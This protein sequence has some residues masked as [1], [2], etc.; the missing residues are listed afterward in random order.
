M[1]ELIQVGRRT[2]YINCPSKIGVY[3]ATDSGAYIIDSGNDK[4]AGKKIKKILD[5]NS[6]ELKG[7]IN[8]HSHADHIGG[9]RYLQQQTGCR[10]F[11]K[12]IEGSFTKATL[13]EPAL[14]YGG[15]P[16]KDLRHKFLMA[17]ESRCEDINS[18]DFPKELEVVD[19]PGHYFEMIGIKT[20]DSVFFLADSVS[21]GE[22]LQKYGIPFI[23]DIGGYLE[24]LDKIEKIPAQLYVPSHAGAVSDI[25]GLAEINRRSVL[26]TAD[27]IKE[28]ISAPLNFEEILKRLF[29][30]YGLKMSFMQYAL[31]GST[32]KSY[33]AWLKDNNQADVE[34]RDNLLLWHR[35]Q[36][37][38]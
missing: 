8:T 1:Y 13:L 29:D 30:F 31:V 25:S 35:V 24:T 5:T 38:V 19:L 33:L 2:Y 16:P 9:N 10:I 7:I 4:D 28:I 21:S 6:W 11:A 37:E 34:I 14:L 3:L 17:E 12:G 18:G 15:Y 36:G 22:T 20:P 26:D 32:V 23:Y 27:K